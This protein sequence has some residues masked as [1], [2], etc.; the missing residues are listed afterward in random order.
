[1]VV[2]PSTN[3]KT[4]EKVGVSGSGFTPGDTV[5]IV[6]CLRTAKG[7]AGCNILGATPATISSTGALPKTS[8]KVSTGAVGTGKCGTTAKN[9]KS[10]A[11]SVGNETGGDSAVGPITFKALKK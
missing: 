6:E 9:L 8:F 5:Y 7:Q 11:V 3:L 1:V 10:C 4:G 2:T